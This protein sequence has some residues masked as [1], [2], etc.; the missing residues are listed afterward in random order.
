MTLN[1]N[2]FQ[3]PVAARDESLGRRLI[4]GRLTEARIACGKNQTELAAEVNVSRQAISAY[5]QGDKVP[6]PGTMR[7]IADVLQQ[8]ISYFTA[9]SPTSFGPFSTNF[10]R[11]TGADTKKR[12]AACAV[13]AKWFA[14]TA[15]AFNDLA[16]FPA[17]DLPAFE[18]ERS[19]DSLYD[20]EEIETIAEKVRSHFGLGLGPISNIV[21]LLETKGVIVCRLEMPG[22]N[23]EAFSFWSGSKPFIFLASDKSSGARAR[24]DA[25]HELGHLVLHRWIGAEETEDK[26]RLREIESEA[27]RFASAFLLPRKSFPNEVYSPRI[28]AFVDLKRRWKVSI[29]AM[30]Y[31]CRDL[32]IFDDQQ[33][34]NL[35]KQISFK[36]WRKSEPLDGDG[37]IPLEQPLLLGKVADLVITSGALARDELLNRLRLAP[38]IVERLAGLPA[39]HLGTES[40]LHLNPTLK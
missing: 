22:E 15:F 9:E 4:P 11:K 38:S 20:E 34:T 40:Q 36:K 32:G 7:V 14:Q 3:F 21:R 10:F 33:V 24:F 12:N 13:H 1:D 25:A 18:P 26:D 19:T 31:R 30:V 8:P 27:D 5:E 2:V 28:M 17:V 35:Y 39:G 16:N 29:Q 6:E 37:G 23:V